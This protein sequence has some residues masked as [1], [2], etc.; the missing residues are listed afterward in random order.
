MKPDCL[1]AQQAISEAYDGSD[2]SPS[3]MRAI[4]AHCASCQ[5]C[6]RFVSGLA[7]LRAVSSPQA[8][9]RVIASTM[10]A[11]RQASDRMPAESMTAGVSPADASPGAPGPTV[12]TLPRALN[13]SSMAW[14]GAAAAIVLA[15][16]IGTVQGVRYMLTPP[17]DISSEA[18]FDTALS[19]AESS[20]ELATRTDSAYGDT[21]DKSLAVAYEG[22]VRYVVFDGMVYLTSER[23]VSLSGRN[24]LP[25][26]VLTDLGTG[27]PSP[28][29][30][31]AAR[32]G[33]TIIVGSDDSGRGLEATLVTRKLGG[34]TFAL[35]SN[36]I[37]SFGVW[38]SLPPEYATPTS[39]NGSPTF[40]PAGQDDSRVS[41]FASPGS[42]PAEGFA[43]APGASGRDP[44]AGN[45]NWT[46][47][48]PYAP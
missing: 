8:P 41:V 13:R 34:V 33:K 21:D 16:G 47:W 27:S 23:T 26:T 6:G 32:D 44:I 19:A 12:I 3:E 46:W 42:T 38:P 30:V 2:I 20:A 45:P 9:E 31:Y 10:S 29:D 17:V 5:D 43:I 40:A 22:D 48:E 7:R 39:D 28:R 35:R 24:L 14:I 25:G 37:D 15:V 1:R 36:R 4:K 11:V 18:T